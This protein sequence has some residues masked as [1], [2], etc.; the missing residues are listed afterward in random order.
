MRAVNRAN[1]VLSKLRAANRAN[2]ELGGNEDL[3]G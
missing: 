2:E 3:V 1:E